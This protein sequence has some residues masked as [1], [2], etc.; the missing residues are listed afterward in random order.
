MMQIFLL[1]FWVIALITGASA[2]DEPKLSPEV[3][4]PGIISTDLDESCG[5]F[6]PDGQTFYFVRRGAYTTPPPISIICFSEF[7]D[8]KWTRP[9][10][11][12]FSGIYLDGSPC[13]SPDGKRLY[14][15]SKRPT[16]SNPTGSDW[17]MWFVDKIDNGWSAPKEIGAA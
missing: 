1:R 6:S 14:F 2:A 15:E 13:F 17:N 11:A 16:E 5:S 3:F 9:E 7:R 10:V 8:G 12:P 4:A